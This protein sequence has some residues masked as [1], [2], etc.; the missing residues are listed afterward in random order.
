VPRNDEAIGE[1]DCFILRGWRKPRKENK[2]TKTSLLWRI[3]TPE[4]G[5]RMRVRLSWMQCCEYGLG[6]RRCEISL[7][8]SDTVW[9]ARIGT[10][11]IF[12]VILLYIIDGC[13]GIKRYSYSIIVIYYTTCRADIH[14][15]IYSCRYLIIRISWTSVKSVSEFIVPI[16]TT[17]RSCIHGFSKCRLVWVK[18]WHRHIDSHKYHQSKNRLK[19][20]DTII[21]MSLV[22]RMF[23]I[24]LQKEQNNY[25]I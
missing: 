18:I 11:C 24:P 3:Q 22:L 12:S 9:E 25:N 16:R 19:P 17:H 23:H 2:N 8:N 13:L 20:L 6:C 10:G 21:T 1:L 14:L 7:D 4:G 5:T 15:V